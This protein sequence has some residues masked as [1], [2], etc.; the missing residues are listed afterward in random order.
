MLQDFLWLE[1]YYGEGEGAQ[2]LDEML[3]KYGSD[4]VMAA[5]QS[6]DLVL[7]VN[8]M[9]KGIYCALSDGAREKLSMTGPSKV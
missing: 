7:R 4:Q 1:E 8:M 5:L 3:L 2:R 6:E 9:A